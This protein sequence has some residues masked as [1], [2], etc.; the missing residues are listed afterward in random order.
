MANKKKIFSFNN[1]LSLENLSSLLNDL[2][3]MTHSFT[4]EQKVC[5][6]SPNINIENNISNLLETKSNDNNEGEQTLS[7]KNLNNEYTL[8]ISKNKSYTIDPIKIYNEFNKIS[9]SMEEFKNSLKIFISI[10]N[11]FN[12]DLFHWNLEDFNLFNQDNKIQILKFN[13]ENIDNINLEECISQLYQKHLSVINCEESEVYEIIANHNSNDLNS[14]KSNDDQH[15]DFET[16][17]NF[18]NKTESNDILMNKENNT[19]ET[20]NIFRNIFFIMNIFNLMNTFYLNEFNLENILKNIDLFNYHIINDY[21][22][23]LLIFFYI[24]IQIN[25]F[26]NKFQINNF[27]KIDNKTNKNNLNNND[28][29]YINNYIP[30]LFFIDYQYKEEKEE[31]E[32][33]KEIII[34]LNI[35]LKLFIF[36][37]FYK[38]KICMNLNIKIYNMDFF[39]DIKNKIIFSQNILDNMNYIRNI[40]NFINNNKFKELFFSDNNSKNIFLLFSFELLL[41]N[42]IDVR[43][44][45]N[46]FEIN[47]NFIIN[48]QVVSLNSYENDSL[49]KFPLTNYLNELEILC[50][51]L[52]FLLSIEKSNLKKFAFIFAF[53]S[54]SI[55]LK[56]DIKNKINNINIKDLMIHMG[57]YHYDENE[58]VKY[59][60][61]NENFN[62]IYNQYIQI[63]KSLNQF[64]NYNI[65]VKLFKNGIF[66]NELKYYFFTLFQVIINE[67]N[68]NKND[69]LNKID[70]YEKKFFNNVKSFF[71]HIEKEQ[72]EF[73]NIFF[74]ALI[75]ERN[76]MSNNYNS[77]KIKNSISPNKRRRNNKNNIFNGINIFNSIKKSSNDDNNLNIYNSINFDKN[78]TA[79]KVNQRINT[80]EK[81][82]S[83]CQY[84][85]QL[86][87]SILVNFFKDMKNYFSDFLF[88]IDKIITKIKTKDQNIDEQK[89]IFENSS[90]NSVVFEPLY[91]LRN[92]TNNKC[93]FILKDFY[94]IEIYIYLYDLYDHNTEN[95]DEI[96]NNIQIFNEIMKGINNLKEACKINFTSKKSSF[97]VG[98][99]NFIM[100]K[101]FLILNQ[102]FNDNK[103]FFNDENKIIILDK[104]TNT[105]CVFEQSEIN[106]VKYNK[107]KNDK[108]LKN[109]INKEDDIFIKFY[110]TFVYEYDIIKYIIDKKLLKF[111]KLNI[112]I[113][114][115]ILQINKGQIQ[116]K[117]INLNEEEINLNK[118]N[119]K[120]IITKKVGQE[121]DINS[122]NYKINIE[123]EN[124]SPNQENNINNQSSNEN[125][126]LLKIKQLFKYKNSYPL[127][128]FFLENENEISNLSFLIFSFSE[129]F[130][131]KSYKELTKEIII[132]RIIKFFHCFKSSKLTP[133]IFNEKYLYFF[134]DF[135]DKIIKTKILAS[136]DSSD[137]QLTNKNTNSQASQIFEK[138]IF[139]PID[140]K[141]IIN[142]S[143]EIF[144]EGVFN[145]LAKNISIFQI[146]N[147]NIYNKNQIGK[148]FKFKS[149]INTIIK[150]GE[151]STFNFNEKNNNIIIYN[152]NSDKLNILLRK[153]LKKVKFIGINKENKAKDVRIFDRNEVVVKAKNDKILDDNC[154]IY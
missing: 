141:N 152:V 52:K 77:K 47:Y 4:N 24:S 135:F 29:K 154:L 124:N 83:N 91:L 93:F 31:N 1:N 62:K 105:D 61:D 20:D 28:N 81:D 2:R 23:L 145:N 79:K 67:L 120:E 94:Y 6:E 46:L 21:K 114:R 108:N 26:I 148:L 116:L 5:I 15:D 8:I 10:Y 99:I 68:I 30:N 125:Y 128:I 130:L 48:C 60:S 74:P 36:N 115:Q 17:I 56:K 40:F 59:I 35:Y 103:L 73:K 97:K 39:K 149:I 87:A 146:E 132:K 57:I 53:N 44:L 3:I 65:Q 16:S 58:F 144:Q 134:L 90:D 32:L 102:Y 54:F 113:Q 98:K 14:K 11:C 129:I 123:N 75:T 109:K 137:S 63:L 126:N 25:L 140:N 72:I 70:L 55:A 37:Y 153:N 133:I 45:D 100:Q 117:Y 110:T 138:V 107:L 69:I 80:F 142:I 89:F 9:Y 106:I 7:N 41:I 18:I 121:I 66:N 101:N 27:L 76:N 49:I 13:K 22:F 64:K 111:N 34:I 19:Y 92:F 147:N 127:I 122:E 143:D 12:D 84:I 86:E 95:K 96:K 42:N 139:Y 136:K 50:C 71:L 82:L 112:I 119:S 88:Y 118:K 131:S 151:I 150:L 85:S 78:D 43:E 51:A 38:N 33:I 104:F